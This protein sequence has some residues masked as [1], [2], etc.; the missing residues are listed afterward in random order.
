MSRTSRAVSRASS[1]L[2]VQKDLDDIL[3]SASRTAR[4]LLPDTVV[5]TPRASRSY[6]APFV[7]RDLLCCCE[8]FLPG[9]AS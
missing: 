3:K 7:R 8:C 9:T 5:N 6:R 4:K 1:R 2:S